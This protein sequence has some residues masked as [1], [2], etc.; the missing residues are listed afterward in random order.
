MNTTLERVA[1]GKETVAGPRRLTAG[2]DSDL[3]PL[4]TALTKRRWNHPLSRHGCRPGTL[5][6]CLPPPHR[7]FASHWLFG[8]FVNRLRKHECAACPI[9]CV[10]C[11]WAAGRPLLGSVSQES[12]HSV[13]IGVSEPDSALQ[14]MRCGLRLAANV[15]WSNPGVLNRRPA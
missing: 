2:D 5:I 14:I 11:G 4:F 12:R 3:T 13:H 15:H 8:S 9:W 10:V 1:F 7:H 6:K